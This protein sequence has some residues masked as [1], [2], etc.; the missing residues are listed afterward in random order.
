MLEHLFTEDKVN[1]TKIGFYVGVDPSNFLQAQFEESIRSEI[2]IIS[3]IAVT[4][5]PQFKCGYALPTFVDNNDRRVFSP[6]YD[7]QCC[8]SDAKQLIDMLET[9]YGNDGSQFVFYRMRH[10]NP[11]AYL[12]AIQRQQQYLVNKRVIPIQ[13]VSTDMMSTLY[14]DLLEI[15]GICEILEHKQTHTQGRWSLM[16]TIEHF[17]TAKILV[18][19]VLSQLTNFEA[20]LLHLPP[21]RL[22]FKTSACSHRFH[23][24]ANQHHSSSKKK[25]SSNPRSIPLNPDSLGNSKPLP[26]NSFSQHLLSPPAPEFKISHWDS[27]HNPSIH[28]RPSNNTSIP[29][30][31]ST[32]PPNSC[33]TNSHA[34]YNKVAAENNNTTLTLVQQEN[35]FLHRRLAELSAQVNLLLVQINQLQ[36]S[37]TPP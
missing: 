32:F 10:D 37:V 5:I 35:A 12:G 14:Y 6:S 22:A 21:C 16:T 19:N 30:I 26:K 31:I 3:D 8:Q 9:T 4:S 29:S 2:S 20:D 15:E 18:K 23:Q 7:L 27:Q 24:K 1:I 13:G 17:S 36:Q 33:A 28:F 34:T 11:T 25:W